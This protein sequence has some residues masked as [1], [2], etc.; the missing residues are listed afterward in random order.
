MFTDLKLE[1]A[2]KAKL[3]ELRP[4]LESGTFFTSSFW[5]YYIESEQLLI[6]MMTPPYTPPAYSPKGSLEYSW[7]LYFLNNYASWIPGL[8]ASKITNEDWT[9][10][11]TI[12]AGNGVCYGDGSLI[13]VQQYAMMD[14]RW[15]AAYLGYL[16][17]MHNKHPFNENY[18]VT[19]V[20]TTSQPDQLT[21]GLFGDWGTAPKQEGTSNASPSADVMTQL[22]TLN[23]D[24]LIHLGDVY[25]QGSVSE[26]QNNLLNQWK[27]A[28]IA[29]FALNSNHEMYS[30][31]YGLFNPTLSN[32]IFNAQAQSTFFQINY[33][34]WIILGLDSAYNSTEVY[35]DGAITDAAQLS[36]LQSLQGWSAQG[37][38]L[39]ILTHHNPVIEP[40]GETNSLWTDVTGPNG[41][42]ATPDMWYWGHI[43]NGIVYANSAVTGSTACRCLGHAAIPYGNAT[44]FENNTN[45]DFYTNKT[46]NPS[47]GNPVQAMNGFAILTLYPDGGISETWYYQDGSTAWT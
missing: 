21:L 34:N 4:K 11:G 14:M 12:W 36:L 41:L 25:Y 37:K 1:T 17:Y 33:G 24:I 3:Q 31:A 7:V 8:P 46:P 43:H 30:G 23:P 18:N 28:P 2:V 40:G 9:N 35:M 19:T 5:E 10:W 16:E 39:L 45:I 42:N 44:W 26:E 20:S 15:A 38:K 29:N 13:N 22:N 6:T 32:S 47:T 27:P